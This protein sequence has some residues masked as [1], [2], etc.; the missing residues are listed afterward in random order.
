L[1]EGIQE[2]E[3]GAESREEEMDEQATFTFS[4]KRKRVREE[5]DRDWRNIHQHF[6]YALIET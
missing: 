5:D 2:T 6:T 3:E 4:Q 1:E